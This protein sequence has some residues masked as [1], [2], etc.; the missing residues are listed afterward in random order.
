[1][2]GVALDFDAMCDD[3]SKAPAGCTILLHACA[4]NPTGVDPT[5]VQWD[6]LAQIV[7]ERK[8]IPLFDSAYQGYASGDPEADA[9]SVRKFEQAGIDSLICQSFAKNMGL[10]G[11]R[12]GAL[13]IMCSDADEADR[14]K[15]QLMSA[16]IRPNYSSPPLHG[17]RLAAMVLGDA[18]LRYHCSCVM[19]TLI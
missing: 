19:A 2:K 17:S 9:L 18:A 6:T 1:M 4:H 10:Y 13:N 15:S 12:V 3:L 11:E 16:V 8:L 7:K 14:V 5:A